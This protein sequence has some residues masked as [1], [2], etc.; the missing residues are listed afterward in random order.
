MLIP[1][2]SLYFYELD[3]YDEKSQLLCLG[4]ITQMLQNN[5]SSAIKEC[6][7]DDS[8]KAILNIAC[9][10]QI[11]FKCENIAPYDGPRPDCIHKKIKTNWASFLKVQAIVIPEIGLKIW[12]GF[13]N[14]GIWEVKFWQLDIGNEK[15]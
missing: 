12:G 10:G 2:I 8:C 9:E 1:I 6:T 7:A 11:F 15:W 3:G 13:G 4:I 14:L 5:T